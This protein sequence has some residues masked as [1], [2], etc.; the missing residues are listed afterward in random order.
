MSIKA[1]SSFNYKTVCNSQC[2]CSCHTVWDYKS[3]T[4]LHK[5]FGTL[6]AG[7]SGYPT[8]VF[9][10][11]CCEYRLGPHAF[12]HYLFPSWFLNAAITFAFT[13]VS[14]VRV[15]TALAVRRIVPAGADIFRLANLNDV[16]GMKELLR[17]GLASPD[18]SD[19]AGITV[20]S[21][22]KTSS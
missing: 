20:L 7:Y 16:D 17:K 11:C 10:K 9:Q 21:V 13:R 15:H 19:T 4:I 8:Q 2:E 3:P 5:A 12:F 1:Y 22:S 6:F 18:D 14:V